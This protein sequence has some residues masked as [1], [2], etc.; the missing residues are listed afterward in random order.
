MPGKASIG[1]C[2][3][4]AVAWLAVPGT[5]AG[6]RVPRCVERE[7]TISW[8]DPG[9][10]RRIVG[11]ERRDVIVGGP[12]PEEID[13]GGGHDFICAGGGADEIHGG[14]GI[15]RIEAGDLDDTIFPGPGD[16][17]VDGGRNL[18]V[19]SQESP[20]D[21][22]SY[23]KAKLD[24]PCDS[25]AEIDDP[26]D[27]CQDNLHATLVP[28][29]FGPPHASGA[30][31]FDTLEG[32]ESIRGTADQFNELYG[33]AGPNVLIDGEKGNALEGGDGNDLLFGQGGADFLEGGIGNDVLDGG[34][35]ANN[36]SDFLDGGDG[37]DSCSNANPEFISNCE[38][39]G[40]SCPAPFRG[41]GVFAA[42][43]AAARAD[44]CPRVVKFSFATRADELPD[45]PDKSR[46]PPGTIEL[47][48]S[49]EDT[50]LGYDPGLDDYVASGTIR[51]DVV[52]SDDD[53]SFINLDLGA[54]GE[55]VRKGDL[56]RVNFDGVVDQSSHPDC[57][58][59]TG[60]FDGAFAVKKERANLRLIFHGGCLSD[61]TILWKQAKK[62]RRAWIKVGRG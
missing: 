57:D 44:S 40:A 29:R 36:G 48:A 19:K 18:P 49:S 11:T 2:A 42:P 35:D 4:I 53:E 10:G 13:A 58:E 55:Y 41:F 22:V 23:D 1:V 24:D 38:T 17:I 56:R 5:S 59:S 12:D 8:E 3:L 14:F 9:V 25:Q 32:I 62:F 31:G 7:A 61:Q 33:D 51:L 52:D 54:E 37:Y 20:G 34:S 45:K 6:E 46:L 43:F 15:D 39:S 30:G 50:K 60:A 26:L 27:P 28:D 21:L 16:D 47:Q